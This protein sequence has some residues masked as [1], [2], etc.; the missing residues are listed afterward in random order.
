MLVKLPLCVT[1]LNKMNV[2]PAASGVAS[3]V[4]VREVNQTHLQN[5]AG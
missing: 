5:K 2:S 1:A 4:W 3:E